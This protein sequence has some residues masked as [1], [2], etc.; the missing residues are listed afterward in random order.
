V[1][2]KTQTKRVFIAVTLAIVGISV[3]A[4]VQGY[5]Y[6]EKQ[7]QQL[8]QT[9]QEKVRLQQE[10]EKKQLD[11]QENQKQIEQLKKDLQAKRDGQARAL[12]QSAVQAPQSVYKPAAGSHTD[13]MAQAGISPSDY[14]YVDYIISHE[15]GWR[16]DARNSIG[17]LGLAQACPGQKI[18][19]VCPDLN[20]VCQLKWASSYANRYGGWAGS[21]NAW[22]S[23]SWW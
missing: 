17:C 5:T 1:K 6:Q 9:L 13:W 16:P 7:R 22:Q 8:Q 19:N 21:Y 23:K 4:L 15:S 20:P 3:V 12:A 11:S 10:L 18:L 2:H 14:G